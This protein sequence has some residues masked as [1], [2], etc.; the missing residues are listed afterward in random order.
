MKIVIDARFYGLEHAGL[1]R[2]TINLIDQL[3][4]LDQINS[5]CLLINNSNQLSD[6]LPPNF[7]TLKI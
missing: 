7:Q 6:K 2:Y 1:G 3:I 5:Y 4:K